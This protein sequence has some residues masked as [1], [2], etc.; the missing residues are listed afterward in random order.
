MTKR[1]LTAAA[2]LLSALPACA[3]PAAKPLTPPD[4]LGPAKTIQFTATLI[5]HGKRQEISA[6]VLTLPNNAYDADTNPT[7]NMI[8][9]V[10][11]SDGKTQTEYRHSNSS[12]TKVDAPKS[13]QDINATTL[14]LSVYTDFCDPAAFAKFQHD[15]SDA[16]GVYQ[17]T[18][19]KEQDKTVVEVLAVNPAT[20]L[21]KSVSIVIGPA[22]PANSPVEKILLT[23]WKLNA[24]VN[25]S[26]FAYTPPTDAKLSVAPVLLASGTAAPDFTVQD[27]DGKPVKLSDYKGKTVVLDFWATWCGPC[28]SSLPHTTALAKQY[29]NK[30][31]VVLAVNVWDTPAAF[32]AWLPKHPEYAP[33]HF[34][35]DPNSDQSKSVASALYGVSGIPTQY[36]IGP[37]GKIIKSIV[38]YAAGDTQLEDALKTTAFSQA[39]L[40]GKPSI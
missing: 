1:I 40:S 18:L 3:Q 16:P 13:F 10:Y 9:R 26:L 11:A 21:P 36:I 30:N 34:A 4:V 31:V 24:P 35:I 39:P 5:A 29:A 20:G 32:Q 17:K 33:L 27:K 12:Y 37:N 14:A 25:K 19:G 2:F 6:A 28:Q 22:G 8:D 7:T 23:Q 38:G 15:P